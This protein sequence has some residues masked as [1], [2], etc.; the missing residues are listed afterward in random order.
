MPLGEKKSP[1]TRKR[2]KAPHLKGVI[3]LLLVR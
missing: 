1:R 2:K 3:L